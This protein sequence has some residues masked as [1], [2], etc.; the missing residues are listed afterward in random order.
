MIINLNKNPRL[1]NIK[2]VLINL[3]ITACL[4]DGRPEFYREALTRAAHCLR[5]DF[6][7]KS[8]NYGEQ[9]I[10]AMT[11]PEPHFHLYEQ[12]V[13]GKTLNVVDNAIEQMRHK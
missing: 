12:G 9:A 3:E 11:D 2:N 1:Q 8:K 6:G 5:R 7:I 4:T 10:E 13:I